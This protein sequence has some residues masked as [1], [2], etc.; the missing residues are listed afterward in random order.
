MQVARCVDDLAFF[1]LRCDL[2]SLRLPAKQLDPASGAGLH[3]LEDDAAREDVAECHANSRPGLKISI[4]VFHFR[5][6]VRHRAANPREP[7]AP[8]LRARLTPTAAAQCVDFVERSK[9]KEAIPTGQP[10]GDKYLFEA[11]QGTLPQQDDGLERKNLRST[12]QRPQSPA[13]PAAP[14][15]TSWVSLLGHVAHASGSELFLAERKAS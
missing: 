11:Y 7:Q 13:H 14:I 10:S 6:P 15:P 9:P 5:L 3:Q 4:L 1:E 2:V 8:T 12:G